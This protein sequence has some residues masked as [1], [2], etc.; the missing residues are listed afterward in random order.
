LGSAGALLLGAA[1]VL[2][3]AVH[4]GLWRQVDRTITTYAA[5]APCP[6]L[7][8]GF[9]LSPWLSPEAS[10][11]GAGAL[12]ALVAWRS[13]RCAAAWL[14]VALLAAAP[15]EL[16]AKHLVD[17]PAPRSVLSFE[18]PDCAPERYPVPRVPTPR[19]FP[20][21]FAARLGYFATLAAVAAGRLGRWA[22][23]ARP[24]IF[25]VA[26]GAAATRLPFGWHWPSDLLGGLLL[27]AGAACLAL[28]WSAAARA[29]HPPAC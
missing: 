14:L 16:A 8:A 24:A 28:S 5:A 12:A 6:L 1:G 9:A 11:L 17:Q 18:R 13:R 25:V 20:S 2:A 26:A 10:V 4:V 19:A 15:V 21:G 23:A 3:L 7:E 22:H 27:G 29:T